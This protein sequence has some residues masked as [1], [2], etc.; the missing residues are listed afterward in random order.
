M[1]SVTYTDSAERINY[2]SQN[3]MCSITSTDSAGGINYGSRTVTLE[4]IKQIDSIS[5]L[6]EKRNPRQCTVSRIFIVI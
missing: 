6:F 3:V 2:R 1:C 5:K 4:V